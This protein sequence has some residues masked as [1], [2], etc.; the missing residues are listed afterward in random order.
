M[1]RADSSLRRV[2]VA[3]L[4]ALLLAS[5]VAAAQSI[6]DGSFE[7]PVLQPLSFMAASGSTINGS[8][9]SFAGANGSRGLA[10]NGSP[11]TAQT[12]PAPSGNQ[13]AYIQ[14][15]GTLQQSVSFAAGNYQVSLKAVLRKEN[16]NPAGSRLAIEVDGVTRWSGTPPGAIYATYTTPTF[17]LAAGSHTITVRGTNNF[18]GYDNT[19]FVDTVAVSTI[20][21]PPPTVSISVAPSTGLTAPAS[22]ALSATANDSNGINRVE[23]YGDGVLRGTDMT[24]PYSSIWTNIPVGTHTAMAKAFDN[25]G[26]STSASQTFTVSA[27]PAGNVVDGGFEQPMLAANAFQAASGTT[28]TGSPWN[29]A[30]ANGSRGLATNNSPF[31]A[32]TGPAPSGNQVAFIQGDGTVSQTVSSMAAGNYQVSLKAVLRKENHN[33]LGTKL[34][35][36]VDGVA[37]WSGTPPGAIYATYTTPT[38]ALAAGSHTITVR[39]TNNFPGYDNTVFVDTV[40]VSA[41]VNPAPTVSISVTPSTGLT[42][43]ANVT[44]N[45]TASDTDG[46]SRVEFWGDGVYLGAD[47]TA[48]YSWP[49]SSIPA[50]TH[51]AKAIAFDNLGASNSASQIFTVSATPTPGGPFFGYFGDCTYCTLETYQHTNLIFTACWGYINSDP[52]LQDINNCIAARLVEA[53]QQGIPTAIVSIGHLVYIGTDPTNP[54]PPFGS[55]IYRGAGAAKPYLRSLFNQL[56]LNGVLTMVTALYP[57][58]EPDIALYNT[59]DSK[60]SITNADIR[61]VASEYPELAGVKLA[62]IYSENFHFPG[63][64][65]YDWVGF[66]S[67]KN[68]SIMFGTDS[69]D[70][71]NGCIHYP[72]PYDYFLAYVGPSQ[73]ILLVPGG[74]SAPNDVFATDPV[75]FYDKLVADPKVIA[76]IPFLWQDVPGAQIVGIRSNGMA[77]PYCKVG[78]QITGKV[79]VCK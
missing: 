38:F 51:T 11:F 30:G 79:A 31:T 43:P 33:P 4:I 22:V 69:C 78:L 32:Q 12:G 26:A 45:A 67:Y 66:D 71:E 15:D 72:G 58:D 9:W 65:S 60:I 56:R 7:Q 29:Y 17:A 2:Q 59:N 18:P 34:A 73:R 25:L 24:A 70:P 5:S 16:N 44:L 47:N 55:L 75:P 40:A 52:A 48:P 19:V 6:A 61:A 21:N 64:A 46:V 35:I 41:I 76:M 49:W 53:K 1:I 54:Q 39:G 77:K 3:G 57:I 63:I 42:A 28:I 27:P 62:V 13:V 74:A 14:G 23:F 68:D 37:R 50:G 8:P 20:V 10:T 36:E